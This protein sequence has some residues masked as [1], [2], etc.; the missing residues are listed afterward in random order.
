MTA[1][2]ARPRLSRLAL[3]LLGAAACS[4][5]PPVTPCE[6]ESDSVLCSRKKL[7]GAVEVTDG[8][9]EPRSLQC[10]DTCAAPATCGGTGLT[11]KCGCEAAAV[12]SAAGAACGVVSSPAACANR[13]VECGACTAPETCGGGGVAGVCGYTPVVTCSG[14]CGAPQCHPCPTKPMVKL[15]GLDFEIDSTE[16]TNAE[17]A[18]F[19]AD[20]PSVAKL[21]STCSGV[22]LKPSDGWPASSSRAGHPVVYVTWCQAAAYCQ[23]A[24]KHLC[25]MPG[26][27]STP[28]NS[29][30]SVVESQW[31]AACS[32]SGTRVF[33]YGD[34]YEAKTCNGGGT[35]LNHTVPVG[36]LSKCE[37]GVTGLFDM[38][39]NVAEWD[40]SCEGPEPNARCHARGGSYSDSPSFLRCDIDTVEMRASPSAT[41]GF[42]CC[43]G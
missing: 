1:L 30:S 34:D 38:S 12:C 42:R 4:K 27:G 3:A 10:G 2:A 8:C 31:Y 18:D 5:E 28:F 13:T 40:D 14:E 36:S 29:T 7:C 22:S 15:E 6:P 43:R 20:N 9:G 11:G 41:T 32:A 24:G 16:V 39:G 23:W 17:Y 35:L 37:G 21:G 25:G 33:P 19:L 26:G